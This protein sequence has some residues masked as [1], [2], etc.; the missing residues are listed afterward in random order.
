MFYV[1]SAVQTI[2]VQALKSVFVEGKSYSGIQ[3][4]AG[5]GYNES[6]GTLT[7]IDAT[8]GSV[9][10]QKTWPDSCYSG[11][12]STAGN[13]V[14]VGRNSG[15]LQAF[16]ATNGDMLWSFQTGA[17]ANDTVAVFEQDGKEY[18]AFLAAGN[19]LVATAHGDNLWLFSLD[20]TLGPA[21]APGAGTGTEHAGEGGDDGPATLRRARRCSPTT[22][23]AATARSVRAATVART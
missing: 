17:G 5:I 12:V 10:W 18:V 1:C 16:D 23:P 20:G 3:A 2:G 21:A 9:A 19:S 14:F 8:D 7:A 13:V 6:S 11:A 22:A 15:E 4:I